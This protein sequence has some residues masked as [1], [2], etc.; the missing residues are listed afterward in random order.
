MLLASSC[1]GRYARLLAD[2][3]KA[4]AEAEAEIERLQ[5]EEAETK[6]RGRNQRG[7]RG[8]G[9][10]D[11][12]SR[13]AIKVPPKPTLDD[14]PSAMFAE[15]NARELPMYV[16]PSRDSGACRRFSSSHTAAA[17]RYFTQ[18]QQLLDIFTALEE[19][20]LFLIQN[21]QETEQAHE[22]LRQNKR[23]LKQRMAQQD[24]Q[25]SSNIAGLKA[26]AEGEQAVRVRLYVRMASH[27]PH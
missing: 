4:A 12:P 25:L 1:R 24:E 23:A 16:H 8:R 22:E 14:V 7:R 21:A 6:R 2:W 17:Y 20:N 19:S 15:I 11:T 5:E 3:G 9:N 26:Q 13:V 10:E 27:C 18:P